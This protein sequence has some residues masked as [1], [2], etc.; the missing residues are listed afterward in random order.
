VD[1]LCVDESE[2][3]EAL[4]VCCHFRKSVFALLDSKVVFGYVDYLGKCCLEVS[5]GL[6]SVE[7]QLFSLLLSDLRI[8]ELE[9]AAVPFVFELLLPLSLL[10]LVFFLHIQ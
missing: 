6:P 9:Q 10:V 3:A 5:E 1:K 4:F 2:V 8:V 7:V